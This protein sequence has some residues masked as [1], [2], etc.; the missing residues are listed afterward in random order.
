VTRLA[1]VDDDLEHAL[2]F[3]V[4]QTRDLARHAQCRESVHARADE[5]IDDTP[6]AWF[7]DLAVRI[8]RGGKNRI[9]ALKCRGHRR[10]NTYTGTTGP[11]SNAVGSGS[12][13]RWPVRAAL[14]VAPKG[15]I[16]PEGLPEY[17]LRRVSPAPPGRRS[18]RERLALRF[19]S[20]LVQSLTGFARL[21]PSGANPG[22][23][24][25]PRHAR[26]VDV[27]DILDAQ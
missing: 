13:V 12:K 3:V 21:E 23:K 4:V 27:V 8:E 22:A 14:R 25:E 1:A 2:T 19:S 18:R 5:Q 26:V 9:D 20:S 7:V 24:A 16:S 15:A 6:Q 11:R 10:T 17:W